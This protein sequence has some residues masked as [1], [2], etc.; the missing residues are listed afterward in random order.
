V[1]CGY[2]LPNGDAV[3]NPGEAEVPPAGAQLIFLGRGGE[4]SVGQHMH[5]SVV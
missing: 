2:R 5:C 1:L 4:A 3:M